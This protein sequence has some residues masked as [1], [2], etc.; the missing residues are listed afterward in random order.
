[1]FIRRVPDE[2]SAG[3]SMVLSYDPLY[4]DMTNC[5]SRNGLAM[6]VAPDEGYGRCKMG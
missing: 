6:A 5:F 2:V 4:R 1:M 3:T